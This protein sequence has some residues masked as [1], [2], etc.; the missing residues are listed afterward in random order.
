MRREVLCD[1][2]SFAGTFDHQPNALSRNTAASCVQKYCLCVISVPPLL[3]NELRPPLGTEPVFKS[4]QGAG[5]ER[6]DTFFRAFAKQP[7]KLTI[8]VN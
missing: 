6:N 2:S 5:A 8:E 4:Q 3:R 1:A 7:Y